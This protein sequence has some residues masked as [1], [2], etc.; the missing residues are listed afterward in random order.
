MKKEKKAKKPIGFK[1][2]KETEEKYVK[3]DVEMDDGLREM[4]AS[5][6]DQTMSA[7]ERSD[8][9][10]NWAFNDIIKKMVIN[11]AT[12]LKPKGGK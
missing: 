3:L 11:G 8:M 6:A 2:V 10:L 12:Y 9:L 7:T 1:I 5:Y 4:L